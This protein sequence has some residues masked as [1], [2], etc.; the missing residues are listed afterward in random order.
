ML[1][2]EDLSFG[3]FVYVLAVSYF[4]VSSYLSKSLFPSVL[5]FFHRIDY[6]FTYFL[7]IYLSFVLILAGDLF[8]TFCLSL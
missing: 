1:G 3:C 7:F 8:V 4:G 2:L 5:A 6:L